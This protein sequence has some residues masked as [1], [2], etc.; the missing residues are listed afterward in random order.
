MTEFERFMQYVAKTDKCWIWNGGRTDKG[1]GNF[2]RSAAFG[3][4]QI[5][6]PGNLLVCHSCDNPP[7]VNP[8][9]LFLG[10]YKINADDMVAKGLHSNGHPGC[11]GYRRKRFV[12]ERI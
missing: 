10:T 8:T 1:Y 2:R 7:C 11:A 6:A 3:S 5:Y 12:A 4:R 9:H